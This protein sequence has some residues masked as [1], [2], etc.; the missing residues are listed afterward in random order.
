V[1]TRILPRT[2]VFC[3]HKTQRFYPAATHGKPGVHVGYYKCRLCGSS[4]FLGDFADPTTTQRAAA[5]SRALVASMRQ[6]FRSSGLSPAEARSSLMEEA[7]SAGGHDPDL[8]IAGQIGRCICGSDTALVRLDSRG[9]LM[10]QDAGCCGLG[11]YLANDLGL[12]GFVKMFSS[13][14]PLVLRLREPP[15]AAPEPTSVGVAEQESV[16]GGAHG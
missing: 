5:R 6:W 9:R 11:V 7:R 15:I 1:A 12:A 10:T 13:L 4:W 8:G 3:F 14:A 2:C 16:A